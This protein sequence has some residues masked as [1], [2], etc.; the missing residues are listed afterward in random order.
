MLR[1]TNPRR[2]TNRRRVRR[3]A[4]CGSD[5]LVYDTAL[6]TGQ[7]YHCLGCDYVGPLVVETDELP[8]SAEEKPK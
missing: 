1:P 5:R 4:F 8:P 3:C 2:R 6:I 7:R